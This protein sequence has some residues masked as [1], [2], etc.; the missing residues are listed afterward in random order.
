[1][2]NLV[3]MVLERTTRGPA[4]ID[5]GQDYP[6]T[7]GRCVRDLVHVLDVAESH[8]AAL[9]YLSITTTPHRTAR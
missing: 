3:P 2:L 7:H 4:P 8:F 9:D 1:M 5:L 6:T